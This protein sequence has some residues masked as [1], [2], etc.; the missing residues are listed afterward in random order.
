[1]N[2]QI[3]V[4]NHPL[5]KNIEKK[6][7]EKLL[8]CLDIH[9]K[10][11]KKDEYIVL[12]GN[13]INFVG[14]IVNGRIFME[15][16]D[17]FGNKYFYTEIEQHSLFGDVFISPHIKSST[18]N[19]KAITDCTVLFIKYDNIMHF[20]EKNCDYHK[21]LLENLINL[22]ALKSRTLMEKIEIISKKSLRDRILTY[23]ALLAEKQQSNNVISP[24][25]HKEMAEYLCVNRSSM[26]RELSNLQKDDVIDFCKN[27][28][29][30]KRH[31]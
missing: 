12:E 7:I 4:E 19:Y 13:L 10:K 21:Q 5:F 29:S 24:L 8:Q 28:Y 31:I 25:N 3:I 30:L 11:Y 27:N 15:K 26:L 20:C 23:L 22:I 16:E 18:V 2:M 9:E 1:M 14:I 17:Y 6:E